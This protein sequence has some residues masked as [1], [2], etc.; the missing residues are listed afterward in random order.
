MSVLVSWTFLGMVTISM[1]DI[2][3]APGDTSRSFLSGKYRESTCCVRQR[4]LRHFVE[5]A[6]CC[7]RSHCSTLTLPQAKCGVKVSLGDNHFTEQIS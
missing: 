5:N 6:V 3:F 4:L 2:S 1:K 7:K